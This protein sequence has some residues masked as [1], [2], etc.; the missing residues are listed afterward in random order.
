MHSARFL[1]IRLRAR[2]LPLLNGWGFA[3]VG[4]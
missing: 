3:G 1:R 2:F 4:A